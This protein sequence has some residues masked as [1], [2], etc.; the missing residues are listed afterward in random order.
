MIPVYP[1]FEPLHVGHKPLFDRVFEK[2]PPEISEFTFTNMYA[3]RNAYRFSVSM[4]DD[5]LIVRSDAKKIPCFLEP[6]GDGEKKPVMEKII[7]NTSGSFIRIPEIVQKEFEG[8][9]RFRIEFDGA[10]SDY[11]YNARELI[12][13]SGR[14]FDGKRN[15]IKKFKSAYTYE[16]VRLDPVHAKEC[17]G[18]ADAWCIVR[19]CDGVEGLRHERVALEDMCANFSLFHLAG[20]AIRVE[21]KICAVALGERLNPQTLVIHILKADPNMPGLYQLMHHEFVSHE[22]GSLLYVNMEQDLGIEG[23]RKAK[24]SYQPIRR[25]NK[26]TIRLL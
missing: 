6:L 9:S 23:L 12:N 21:G 25:I 11:L 13:L 16:Y 22:A 7:L 10:N 19:D 15:L 26:F 2:N 14:K 4:F 8:D 18:F 17:L 1:A 20:G 24:E 5:F 3:W